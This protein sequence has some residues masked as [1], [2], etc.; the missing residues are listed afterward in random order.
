MAKLRVKCIHLKKSAHWNT[1][2]CK[3]KKKVQPDRELT[4]HSIHQALLQCHI[5]NKSIFSSVCFLPISS[6]HCNWQYHSMDDLD[7]GLQQYIF[8]QLLLFTNPTPLFPWLFLLPGP[9]LPAC[10]TQVDIKWD[11]GWG[12]KFH[13]I[14]VFWWWWVYCCFAFFAFICLPVFLYFRERGL[15]VCFI[16]LFLFL[17]VCTGLNLCAFPSQLFLKKCCLVNF[18]SP[19]CIF[20]FSDYIPLLTFCFWSRLILCTSLYI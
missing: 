17:C 10:W 4:I 8:I 16:L 3:T 20:W 6:V 5:G 7:L 13:H 1:Y 9:D 15:C 18:I 2:F 12:E 14:L 11:W 19:R